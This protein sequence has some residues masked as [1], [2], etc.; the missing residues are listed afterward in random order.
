MIVPKDWADVSVSSNA[1]NLYKL[2][3]EECKRHGILY[4]MEDIITGYKS[5]YES[6]QMTFF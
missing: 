6:R 2:L 3:S 1:R 4:K 5:A